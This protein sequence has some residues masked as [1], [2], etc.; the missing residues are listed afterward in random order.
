MS[1]EELPLSELTE[2]NNEELL[3]R[4]LAYSDSLALEVLVKRCMLRLKCILAHMPEERDDI[5]GQ[6]LKA[7]VPHL[8]P[9]G[10]E[11]RNVYGFIDKIAKHRVI[12]YLRKKRRNKE[13]ELPNNI[14]DM[15]SL[16]L[17]PNEKLLQKECESQKEFLFHEVLKIMKEPKKKEDA[18]LLE[19]K[20]LECLTNQKIA[21]KLGL[22]V[23]NTITK[24]HRAHKSFNEVLDKLLVSASHNTNN[25]I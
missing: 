2:L 16:E 8:K 22:T 12:D 9:G 23:G 10:T 4:W 5:I 15:A 13:I 21:D 18:R 6:V 11:I 1:Y 7:I 24:L 3:R 14:S 25:K 20:H 17:T 19:L